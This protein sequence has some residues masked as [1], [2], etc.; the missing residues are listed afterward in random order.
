MAEFITLTFEAPNVDQLQVNVGSYVAKI[1][2]WRTFWPGIRQDFFAIEKEQYGSQGAHGP[3]GEWEDLSPEYQEKKER[4]WPI[5]EIERAS[6]RTFYSLTG[7]TADS[8][9][10]PTEDS[11]TLGTTVPWAIY[12]QTGFRTR[13]GP[14]PREGHTRA[15]VPARR[16]IDFGDE[17]YRRIVKTMQKVAL[18]EARQTGFAVAGE[19][20]GPGES[21]GAGEAR[22]LGE[23]ALS[24]GPGASLISGM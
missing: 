24:G 8:I 10:E 22:G 21:V 6:G 2:D 4:R 13:L 7:E 19:V 17:D 11:L 15:Y 12:Q 20:Y 23:Q 9:Y 16:L 18:Q 3:H 14:R 1:S 5:N